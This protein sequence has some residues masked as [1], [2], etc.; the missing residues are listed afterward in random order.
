MLHRSTCVQS[1][2]I[3]HRTVDR[4]LSSRRLCKDRGRTHD[5]RGI[6]EVKMRKSL[7]GYI[8]AGAAGMFSFGA[9]SQAAPVT[10]ALSGLTAISDVKQI[11][12]RGDRRYRDN[13]QYRGGRYAGRRCLA[14]G[15]RAGGRGERI[16]GI[17]GVGRGQ[18]ACREAMWEC[19][20]DLRRR[21]RQGRNPVAACVI[22][23]R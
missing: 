9:V 21:Q 12:Y 8:V 22:A 11:Q 2:S 17:V 19:R 13:R 14:V 16:R 5:Q 7:M 4:F 3:E 15:R 6:A 20:R 23:R 1:R 18:G 10:S